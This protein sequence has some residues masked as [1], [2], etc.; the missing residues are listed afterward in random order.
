MPSL[1]PGLLPYLPPPHR[2]PLQIGAPAAR[3]TPMLPRHWMKAGLIFLYF[4]AVLWVLNQCTRLLTPV[5]PPKP[6]PRAELPPPAGKSP[7]K[8]TVQPDL[9]EQGRLRAQKRNARE[10][11][12]A[13]RRT[14]YL[15]LE[16]DLAAMMQS[17][18]PAALRELG[19]AAARYINKL[20]DLKR[21]KPSDRWE[22]ETPV[23]EAHALAQS[24]AQEWYKIDL[25]AQKDRQGPTL[26]TS[27]DVDGLT[28]RLAAFKRGEEE[29]E[30]FA[31]ALAPLHGKVPENLM[32]SAIDAIPRA[33]LPKDAFDPC[34]DPTAC[35]KPPAEAPAQPEAP[36][37]CVSIF[38]P[39]RDLAVFAHPDLAAPVLTHLSPGQCGLVLTRRTQTYSN[40]SGWTALAQ[41]TVDGKTGWVRDRIIG[42]QP[43]HLPAPRRYCVNGARLEDAHLPL[44]MD[45]YPR[46][47]VIARIASTS[48]RLTATGREAGRGLWL[49]VTHDYGYTGWVQAYYLGRQR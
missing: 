2:R 13:E 16:A 4:M 45:P 8:P 41:I 40:V 11:A 39:A 35:Q 33:V 34:R 26:Y 1:K 25:E 49:E 36:P 17:D 20:S 31:S 48:C 7:P 23:K 3:G 46:A 30:A 10:T 32:L 14:R 21:L 9:L 15:A 22:R 43:P 42:E 24:L 29:I 18:I 19:Q 47:P 28:K 6:P 12:R 44:L 5:E 37:S 27:A 38:A